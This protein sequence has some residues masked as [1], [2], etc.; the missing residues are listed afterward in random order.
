MFIYTALWNA[1]LSKN[2]GKPMWKLWSDSC[3]II[4]WLHVITLSIAWVVSVRT[5]TRRHFHQRT[6][7][8]SGHLR[9]RIVGNHLLQPHPPLHSNR[10]RC[11]WWLECLCVCSRHSAVVFWGTYTPPSGHNCPGWYSPRPLS[12]LLLTSC[13]RQ[14][15]NQRELGQESWPERLTSRRS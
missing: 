3:L 1:A 12:S 2:F 15:W 10:Y 7:E 11:S 13:D 9:K 4:I 6:K 8:L 14:A 5:Q